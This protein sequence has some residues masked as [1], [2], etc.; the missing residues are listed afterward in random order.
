MLHLLAS[1]AKEDEI[2]HILTH[3]FRITVLS[4]A[5]KG[6]LYAHVAAN[7]GGMKFLRKIGLSQELLPKRAY[8]YNTKF[9]L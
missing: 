2:M 3:A 1:K 7:R 9:C 4:E 6:F 8:T 5:A